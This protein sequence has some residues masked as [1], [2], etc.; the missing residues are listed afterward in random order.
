MPRLPLALLALFTLAGCGDDVLDWRNAQ[1]SNG[2][3]YEGSANKPFSGKV[4]N[5]P[6]S[7]VLGGQAGYQQLIGRGEAIVAMLLGS[8]V[9]C[10]VK[11][12]DGVLKGEAVCRRPQQTENEIEAHFDNGAL[13][14]KFVMRAPKTHN[15]LAETTFKAGKIDGV[16]KRYDPQTQ[17]QTLEQSVKAG[18]AEG[19]LKQWDGATG[20][21]LLDANFSKGVP[22]GKYLQNDVYGNELLNGSYKNGLFTG[23][24]TR[25][26]Y[27]EGASSPKTLISRI[28]EKVVAGNIVNQAEVDKAQANSRRIKECVWDLRS[29]RQFDDEKIEYSARISSYIAQCQKDPEAAAKLREARHPASSKV[30]STPAA[31]EV[32]EFDDERLSFPEESNACTEA[33]ADAFRKTAGED[34]M[35]NYA[36]AWE[37]VDNCRAGKRP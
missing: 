15:M 22:E 8:S 18:V 10:D 7:K 4:T 13:T 20:Q 21:L 26:Y 28:T 24:R 35:I 37:F 32:D 29:M 33:W 23:D 31:K 12:H 34:A 2:K 6:Y 11:V 36:L 27:L 30:S 14:G 5:M 3:V 25:L 17:K 19:R 1:F 9:L 16:L